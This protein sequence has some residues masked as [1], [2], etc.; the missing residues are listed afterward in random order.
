MLP[1][2]TIELWGDLFI[3][4]GT[5]CG[6]NVPGGG[7]GDRVAGGGPRGRGMDALAKGAETG[8]AG[9]ADV[10]GGVMGGMGRGVEVRGGGGV[11]GG[12]GD[13]PR[14]PVG[15]KLR[16]A[17]SIGS[18]TEVRWLTGEGGRKAPWPGTEGKAEVGAGAVMVSWVGGVMG[19]EI[20]VSV[21]AS[22]VVSCAG[23][24]SGSMGGFS[25]QLTQIWL[26]ASRLRINGV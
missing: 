16:R 9:A 6:I 19:A 17:S 25:S 2:M 3:S 24:S 18:M 22:G 21:G 11:E 8:F 12:R 23:V 14:R 1:E 4:R 10:G 15:R 13:P 5:G 20:V 7:G 26:V